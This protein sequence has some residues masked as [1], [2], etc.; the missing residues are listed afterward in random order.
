MVL[1]IEYIKMYM[2]MKE[3]TAMINNQT[4][5]LYWSFVS[6]EGGKPLPASKMDVTSS[7]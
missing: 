2:D 6:L 5:S 7:T 3:S 1:T 4:E